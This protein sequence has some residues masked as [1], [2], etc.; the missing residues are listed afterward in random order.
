MGKNRPRILFCSDS[1]GI[2]TGYGR[3][4]REI[5]TRLHRDFEVYQL[6][7]F[8][9][10]P[11]HTLPFKIIPTKGAPG[12]GYYTWDAYGQV[13]FTE[14]V[15][16]LQPDIVIVQGDIPRI[17]H[18]V[19]NPLRHTYHLILYLPIDV[20]PI[21]SIWKEFLEGCD[22]IYTYTTWAKDIISTYTNI[23]VDGVIPLGVDTKTFY[24][25]EEK[26]KLELKKKFF[27]DESVIVAGF[28]G[29][30]TER[31][32]ID[33][34][35]QAV[36]I[37]KNGW[38]QEK[39]II[40]VNRLGRR[41][42]H[43]KNWSKNLK[44]L[45]HIPDKD[46]AGGSLVPFMFFSGFK[47]GDLVIPHRIAPGYG[48]SDEELRDIYNTMDMYVSFATEGFGIPILEAMSCGL[49]IVT[50]NFSSHVEFCSSA[51]ILVD[52]ITWI[53]E[54][55][56]S[57]PRPIPDPYEAAKAL[58]TLSHNKPLRES[59][60][61]TAREKALTM[62]WNKVGNAWNNVVVNAYKRIKLKQK[63]NL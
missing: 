31:K 22:E 15:Q 25:Y 52:P 18:Y 4:A 17:Q 6:G 13:S 44:L 46:P 8:H 11:R 62:S 10:K 45:L 58:I 43:T 24:P 21:P 41:S 39:E 42:Y 2:D 33:Q 29:R 37:A 27:G 57:F 55:K 3:A 23:D 34:I 38:I 1:A 48:V 16:Q 9:V 47:E 49:P 35:I 54:A 53:A 5:C 40:R 14:A 7:W 19:K 36:G 50:I 28:V 59:K 12:K 56:T 20:V 32:R 26:K 51:S 60:G 30:N 63:Q 61:V